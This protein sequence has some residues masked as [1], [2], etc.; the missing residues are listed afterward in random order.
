M[1][2]ATVYHVPSGPKNLHNLFPDIDW[3]LVADYNIQVY[4]G[5]NAIVA[6]S[7]TSEPTAACE[8]IRVHFVNSLGAVDA[9]NFQTFMVTH[10]NKSDFWQESLT[11]GF[12]KSEG[13]MRRLNINANDTC[14]ASTIIYGEQDMPWL[15]ELLD[16]P[17]AWLE[18]EG[19]QGQPD[20][21]LPI[22]ITDSK[23]PTRK[24]DERF[25]NEF[26]I[27]FK[28]ANAHNTIRT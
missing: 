27:E 13:G 7:T 5:A 1:E 8:Y 28:M 16:S 12:K 18:W 10:E 9:V 19:I 25:S 26:T 15:K 2:T 22:L 23:Q 11:P 21:Y 3:S 6:T 4:N 24:E 14:K 17:L 20:D